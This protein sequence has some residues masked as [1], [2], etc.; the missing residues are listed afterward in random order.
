MK[1]TKRTQRSLLILSTLSILAAMSAVPHAAFAASKPNQWYFGLSASILQPNQDNTTVLSP[2]TVDDQHL[3]VMQPAKIKSNYAINLSTGMLFNWD[4]TL[5][6]GM[7]LGL[8]FAHHGLQKHTGEIYDAL[9]PS[10]F[11]TDYS[12]QMNSQTILLDQALE[13]VTWK[14]FTPYI[15]TGV[16]VALNSTENYQATTAGDVQP[17]FAFANKTSSALAY[18]LGFGVDYKINRN[19]NVGVSYDYLNQGNVQLAQANNPAVPSLKNKLTNQ[20]ITLG[21]RYEFAK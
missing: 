8:T 2:G 15:R 10:L 7:R 11:T 14:N 16:G 3:I 13:L 9:N 1:F 17:N 6:P 20:V 18:V 19:W 4:R 5:F 21:V 12:Y